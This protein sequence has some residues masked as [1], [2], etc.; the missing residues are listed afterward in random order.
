MP[1]KKNTMKYYSKYNDKLISICYG[2]IYQFLF[3]SE[4]AK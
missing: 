4:Q 1:M 3:K 2:A